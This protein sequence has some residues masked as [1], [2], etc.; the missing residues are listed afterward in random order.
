[1]TFRTVVLG[2]PPAA[3]EIVLLPYWPPVYAGEVLDCSIDWSVLL[4]DVGETVAS[5]LLDYAPNGSDEL[6]VSAFTTTGTI[7][8]VWVAPLIPGRAYIVR[9]AIATRGGRIFEQMVHLYIDAALAVYPPVD[10]LNPAFSTP[11]IWTDASPGYGVLT[12]SAL[13]ITDE[14]NRPIL[15]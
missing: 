8:T 5:A 15:A 13:A 6:T 12:S 7:S 14:Q 11:A 3:D 10:P 4:A 9:T 2:A 1:M